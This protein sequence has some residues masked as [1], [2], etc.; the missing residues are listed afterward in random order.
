MSLSKAQPVKWLLTSFEMP[1]A[2]AWRTN[3]GRFCRREMGLAIEGLVV[4]AL[5]PGG[6]LFEV[7]LLCFYLTQGKQEHAAGIIERDGKLRRQD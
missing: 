2:M 3:C 5:E 6:A 7:K 1:R 4:G